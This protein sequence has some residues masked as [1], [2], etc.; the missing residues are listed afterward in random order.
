MRTKFISLLLIVGFLLVSINTNAQEQDL[1]VMKQKSEAIQLNGKLQNKK[2]EL[3]REKQNNVKIAAMVASLN[4]K[5]ERKTDQFQSSDPKSTS[6]EA[7]KTAKLLR[8]TESENNKLRKSD[9]KVLKLEKE[10]ASIE[11]KLLKLKYAI[12]ISEK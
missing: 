3:E 5:S 8:E 11:E 12:D 1:K 2:I 6:K 7:K 4:K 9:S 10:V